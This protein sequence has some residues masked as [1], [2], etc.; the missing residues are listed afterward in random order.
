[1]SRVQRRVLATYLDANLKGPRDLFCLASGPRALSFDPQSI[2]DCLPSNVYQS[3]NRKET[4]LI[5]QDSLGTI[6]MDSTPHASRTA[7]R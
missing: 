1:M 4:K 6:A 5:L 3:I 7:Q 2:L